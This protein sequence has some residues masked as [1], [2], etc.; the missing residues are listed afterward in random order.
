MLTNKKLF[1]IVE[2]NDSSQLKHIIDNFNMPK[3]KKCDF[4]FVD[5]KIASGRTIMEQAI[6][7]RSKECFDLLMD[8]EMVNKSGLELS[9]S[10]L[11][12]PTITN[13]YYFDKLIQSDILLDNYYITNYINSG[14]KETILNILYENLLLRYDPIDYHIILNYIGNKGKF[15]TLFNKYE[16]S[17]QNMKTLINYGIM[18]RNLDFVREICNIM[19]TNTIISDME[20]K[21][22]FYNCCLYYAIETNDINY[23]LYIM[24]KPIQ[25]KTIG[26]NTSLYHSI[27]FNEDIFNYFY[28]LYKNL[29]PKELNAIDNIDTLK[30]CIAEGM[31]RSCYDQNHIKRYKLIISTLPVKFNIEDIYYLIRCSVEGIILFHNLNNVYEFLD[32]L[33]N[34]I[35]INGTI[36]EISSKVIEDELIG[37]HDRTYEKFKNFIKYDDKKN[38]YK[39]FKLHSMI[40]HLMNVDVN[41]MLD[42]EE[43]VFLKE[44]SRGYECSST[45]INNNDYRN[46]GMR[47]RDEF[48]NKLKELTKI[49]KKYNF[50]IKELKEFI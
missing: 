18:N 34:Y 33:L 17:V 38:Q 6:T 29:D 28:N 46:S 19:D 16:K 11:A 39:D 44:V 35:K 41:D 30:N 48:K 31:L 37:K 45:I 50:M 47:Y 1:D 22:Q 13:R 49:F 26:N 27:R 14:N 3:Y 5:R 40:L 9:I 36:K 23:V 42:G 25:W 10:Y 12:T 32:F 4:N 8:C 43:I 24:T 15:Y 2:K 7:F 21:K 20:E